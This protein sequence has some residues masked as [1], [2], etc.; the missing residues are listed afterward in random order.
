MV[1][2]TFINATLAGLNNPECA[3]Y[4][5]AMAGQFGLSY[6]II[7]V[8][9]IYFGLRILEKLILVGIP[10]FYEWAKLETRLRRIKN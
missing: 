10:K 9:F 8:A 5:G 2:E 7:R 3:F 1:A 4:V 6:L